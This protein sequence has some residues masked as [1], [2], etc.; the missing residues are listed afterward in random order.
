MALVAFRY[1]GAL[2]TSY[3]KESYAQ[4]GNQLYRR[5]EEKVDAIVEEAL[6][7]DLIGGILLGCKCIW[8]E[9]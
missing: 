6:E 2:R 3:L 7:N 4:L 9:D 1:R 8:R 5:L